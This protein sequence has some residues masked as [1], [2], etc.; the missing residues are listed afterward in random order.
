[1]SDNFY[2]RHFLPLLLDVGCS[3]RLFSKQREAVIPLAHGQVLE[4]GMGTG[5]NVPYYDQGRVKR[6][7]GVDPALQMHALARKRV[8]RAGLNVEM[9]GLSAERLP[10]EDASFDTV[11]C[12]YTLCSIPQPMQALAEMRRVLKPGGQLLFSEH[13]V[14]PDEA[15]RRWQKRLQPVWGAIAGGCQLSADIPK[16]LSSSGFDTQLQSGYLGRP[17]FVGYHYWGVARA[18]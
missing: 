5:L 11:V 13:G 4:V 1:M 17:R 6:V 15:V 18:V 3:L 10:L 7:V 9:V 8:Q 2:E 14:A 16:L 12:T